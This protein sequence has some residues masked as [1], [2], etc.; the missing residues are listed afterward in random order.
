MAV[1]AL[2]ISFELSIYEYLYMILSFA[3]VTC[4][5]IVHSHRD[6]TFCTELSY[7]MILLMQLVQIL[8][9]M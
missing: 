7:P 9:Q 8:Y 4:N 5:C 3:H 6:L 1:C 2:C